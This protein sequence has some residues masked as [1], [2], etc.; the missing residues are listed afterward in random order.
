MTVLM[1][2]L[3]DTLLNDIWNLS[4]LENASCLVLPYI[5]HTVFIFVAFKKTFWFINHQTI[6][7]CMVHMVIFRSFLVLVRK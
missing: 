2:S 3:G 5:I 6:S 4:K 7:L 1:F